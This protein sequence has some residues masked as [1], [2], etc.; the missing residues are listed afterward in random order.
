MESVG[1]R[2]QQNQMVVHIM[3]ES[4]QQLALEGLGPLEGNSYMPTLGFGTNHE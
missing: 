1:R 3:G 2:S 4:N